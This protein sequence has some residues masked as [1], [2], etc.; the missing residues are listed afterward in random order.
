MTMNRILLERAHTT[1]VLRRPF[2]TQYDNP[3]ALLYSFTV[4]IQNV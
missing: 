2:N 4:R 1:P 3:M